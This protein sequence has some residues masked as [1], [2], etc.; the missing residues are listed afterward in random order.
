[1][2]V[3]AGYIK[4][5]TSYR[6]TDKGMR[7]DPRYHSDKNMEHYELNSKKGHI[8]F[9][10]R[11]TNYTQF[12]FYRE[13]LKKDYCEIC[14]KR[15]C[16]LEVHHINKDHSDCGENF[17]NLQTL[18]ASC[19]KKAHY[20]IGR[21]K[22]S[23]KGLDVET[24]KVVSVEYLKDDEVYDVEMYDPYHTFVTSK[25][26]VTCNSHA[27]AYAITA[28][29]GAFLKANY[30][31]AFYTIALQW[32][33]DKEIPSLM[34]EMEQCSKAKIVHPDINVSDVQFFTDY[35]HDEIF[36]SLTRIKMVG[37]KTVEYIV[38][39]RQKNGAF[40]SIENFIHRIFK[41]LSLIHI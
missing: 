19:H 40:T 6:F 8:G 21:V 35:Q 26:I 27:T 38:E 23:E 32:A 29:V 25:G 30:P 1:M 2:Y 20:Q 9:Y 5:D 13:N 4:S 22:Q 33:D 12:K 41:Y 31:S 24:I 11:K 15:D 16:R 7:N 34:S 3:N 28:Y 37:V 10:K 39:E 18:C 36:W 17:S 14:G